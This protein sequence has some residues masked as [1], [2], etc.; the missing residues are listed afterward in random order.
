M[1]LDDDLASMVNPPKTAAGSNNNNNNNNSRAAT[2]APDQG[3]IIQRS[4]STP[5]NPSPI[6]PLVRSCTMPSKSILFND[7][8]K[9]N[10]CYAPPL[11][12]VN[13]SIIHNVPKRKHAPMS[14]STSKADGANPPH[15]SG[16]VKLRHFLQR[17]PTIRWVPK[18][19]SVRPITNLK[20]KRVS[21]SN[22]VSYKASGNNQTNVTAAAAAAVATHQYGE[23]LTNS[24][25]YSCL[26]V[27][28]SIYN[29]CPAL[30]GFGTFGF[31]DVYWKV[32]KYKRQQQLSTKHRGESRPVDNQFFYMAVFDI[33]KCYDHIDT[34]LLYDLISDILKKSASIINKDDCRHNPIDE[35]GGCNDATN[36]C[37]GVSSSLNVENVIHKYSISYPMESMDRNVSKSIRH[38]ALSGDVIPFQEASAEIA[39]CYPYSVIT[40]AVVYPKIT[41]QEMLHVIRVHL[42]QHIVK[43]PVAATTVRVDG[44]Q[45]S[46]REPPLSFSSDA[47]FNQ[48]RGIPQGSV[49]SPLLCSLYYG[50]AER[51]IFGSGEVMDLIGVIDEKTLVIRF[52]DDYIVISTDRSCVQHFLQLAHRDLKLFGGGVNLL[53]TKVN[54]D[55]EVVVEEKGE[56]DDDGV[57][58]MTLQRVDGLEVPWCGLLINSSTLELTCNFGKILDLP[59]AH[60]VVVE[61]SVKPGQAFRRAIKTFM[62]SKCHALVLDARLNSKLTVVR[63]I[64]SMF[65]VSAS[66]TVAYLDKIRSSHRRMRSMYIVECITEAIIFG[67][68]LIKS[69]TARKESRCSLRFEGDS[70][71]LDFGSMCR[72]VV[73]SSTRCNHI[74]RKDQT[75]RLRSSQDRNRDLD[76]LAGCV[77]AANSPDSSYGSC[78]VKRK[79]VRSVSVGVQSCDD[80]MADDDHVIMLKEVIII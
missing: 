71:S 42:F 33:E 10:Y 63:T 65:L 23:V 19:S 75:D 4:N 80:A 50:N 66:R 62:K 48:V 60:S 24:S 56:N 79:E 1:H 51:S 26:H 76:R 11:S 27:L 59:L 49:L 8:L 28:R 52:A 35:G 13:N 54:F 38:V 3:R 44:K 55:C 15:R 72:I 21:S 74:V 67:C 64:Y 29:N 16:S 37:E 70:S 6:K 2:V 58:S 77:S 39:R 36:H 30:T 73:N 46:S 12:E 14:T 69:R 25:L 7:I 57:V 43:I 9:T 53:K 41:Y 47:C 17:V 5:M 22:S 40:D 34:A 18:R 20:C 68:K 61:H 32:L 31:D 45:S 78:P